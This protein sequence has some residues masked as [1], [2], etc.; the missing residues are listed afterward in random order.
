MMA[1][2]RDDL[3]TRLVMRLYYHLKLVNSV[4]TTSGVHIDA[5]GQVIKSVL[6]LIDLLNIHSVPGNEWERLHE[7]RTHCRLTETLLLS[8]SVHRDTILT[9]CT[10]AIEQYCY[11]L[12]FDSI[13]WASVIESLCLTREDA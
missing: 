11:L 8:S 12:E 5:A 13:P 10:E 3:M 6:D 1:V 7:L 2:L 9:E 4:S